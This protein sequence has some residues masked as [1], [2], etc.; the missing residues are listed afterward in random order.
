MTD[1]ASVAVIDRLRGE[2]GGQVIAPDDAG[3]RRG[4]RASGT[5]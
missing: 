3:V 1:D 5:G 4:A 2:V